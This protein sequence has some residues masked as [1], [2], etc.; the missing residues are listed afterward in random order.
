M[1]VS[2]LSVEF[3]GYIHGGEYWAKQEIVEGILMY[4]NESNV[5]YKDVQK[6]W[7]YDSKNV[8]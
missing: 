4:K 2:V 3:H 7:I 5:M 8:I 1:V 6:Y